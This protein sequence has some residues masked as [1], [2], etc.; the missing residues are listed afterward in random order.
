MTLLRNNDGAPI[1]ILLKMWGRAA[2]TFKVYALKPLYRGQRYSGQRSDDGRPLFT[3]AGVVH[4]PF[5]LQYVMQT[6]DGTLYVAD[7]V[8]LVLGP[9]EFKLKRNGVTCAMMQLESNLQ[10]FDGNVWGIKIAPGIDPCLIICFTAIVD[11]IIE[12]LRR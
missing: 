1:A 3:W 5:S 4:P 11:A 9:M 8:G 12:E 2:L 7:R 10:M 6:G